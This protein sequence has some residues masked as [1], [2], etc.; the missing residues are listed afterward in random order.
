MLNNDIKQVEKLASEEAEALSKSDANGVGLLHL[1]CSYIQNKPRFEVTKYLLQAG[2]NP[3]AVTENGN[4]ALHYFLRAKD[5]HA[6][7]HVYTDV[8]ELFLRNKD[9]MM[10][11]NE[12][13][14][15]IRQKNSC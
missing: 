7:Q 11:K 1:A 8:F 15:V 5:A 3:R 6:S 13:V 2:A 14:S 4:T 12:A 9:I 10:M